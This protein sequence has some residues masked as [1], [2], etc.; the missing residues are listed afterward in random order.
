[1]AKFSSSIRSLRII[2]GNV[3]VRFENG[4]LQTT[5]KDEIHAVKNSSSFKDGFI[6]IDEDEAP[7][8]TAPTAPAGNTGSAEAPKKNTSGLKN[9][10]APETAPADTSTGEGNAPEGDGGDP[11]TTGEANA[12]EGTAP[13]T[14]GVNP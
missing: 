12:P 4:K 6:Q 7:A 11:A 8:K 13:A 10:K 9:Q 14:E 3:V 2:D 5:N 1:M